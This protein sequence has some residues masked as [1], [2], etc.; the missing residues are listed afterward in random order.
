MQLD[1]EDKVVLITGAARGIGLET[2]RCFAAEG[3][4]VM[5]VDR[6]AAALADAASQIGNSESMAADLTVDGAADQ[7]VSK[8]LDAFGRLDVLVNNAGISEP[9]PIAGT[10]PESWRRVMA[11]NLDAIYLL[12]RAAMPALGTSKGS[13]VSL[14]S[15]AGKRGTLF[16]DNTSYS[17]SKAGVIGFTR[18]LA[19]EAAKVGVRVN[20]VAPGP[21]ATELIKALTPD[22]LK[23]VTDFVPLGR[24]AET[25]EIAELIVFLSSARAAYIT[26][27][28]VNVNGGLYMD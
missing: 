17:T 23:R 25:R 5:L 1:L 27:E 20:A 16:G 13:V 7:I 14:A 2:A 11:I 10:S 8:A 22:Q 3:A 18:A 12:S 4:R 19:I 6:D 28:V 21:V 26:G 9:A 24:M 15:F